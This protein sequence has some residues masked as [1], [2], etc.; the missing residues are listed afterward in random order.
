MSFRPA[1]A[2]QRIKNMVVSN[3]ENAKQLVTLETEVVDC[4][5]NGSRHIETNFKNNNWERRVKVIDA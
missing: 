1:R 4:E 3:V 5:K 2:T